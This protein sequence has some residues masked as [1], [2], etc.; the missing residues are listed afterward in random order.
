M[1]LDL[2]RQLY[3]SGIYTIA[4]LRGMVTGI[5]QEAHWISTVDGAYVDLNAALREGVEV[6]YDEVGDIVRVGQAAEDLKVGDPVVVDEAGLYRRAEVLGLAVPDWSRSGSFA[7]A[8]MG[9]RAYHASVAYYSDER[10]RAMERAFTNQQGMVATPQNQN[11][12]Q[13][14]QTEAEK[15]AWALL[16]KYMTPEQHFAFMEGTTVEL[17]N[18]AE[19][20]RILINNKGDFNILQGIKAGAGVS[21]SEGRIHSYEY[22]L[23]DQISA[24]LDWFRHRTGEL[25]ANWNCGTYGIVKEGER[26]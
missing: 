7:Y 21:E 15:K 16:E 6:V 26:R 3:Q 18:K 14:T 17:I 24:F 4:E 20:H 10:H 22:P 11:T 25:I 12:Y 8:H 1:V 23:G 5:P 9:S 13:Y 19:T 2:L